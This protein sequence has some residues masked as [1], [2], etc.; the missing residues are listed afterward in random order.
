MKPHTNIARLSLWALAA[1][2]AAAYLLI[3]ARFGVNIPMDDDYHALQNFLLNFLKADGAE[4]LRLM[5]EA[6]NMHRLV[7]MR[8]VVLGVY[9]VSGQLNYSAYIWLTSL[10]LLAIALLLYREGAGR[11]ESKSL[12]AAI[13]FLLLFNGQNLG[14][15]LWAMSGVANIGSVMLTL[16]SIT[17]ILSERRAAFVAG[18]AVSLLTIYSNGNGMLMIPPLLVCL[19]MMKRRR[20]LIAFGLISVTAAA[21]YFI[22]LES[23]RVGGSLTDHPGVKL[24]NTFA[25]AGCNLWIPSAGYIA[26]A[27][28]AACAAIYLWG[29][30][31]GVYKTNL[32][33]Y[34]CLTTLFLTAAATA[35]GNAPVFGGESAAPWRYRIYGSMFLALTAIL[36]TNNPKAFGTTKL[37]RIFPAL[38][39]AF[40]ILS[41]L[42]CYRKAERRYEQKVVSSYRWRTAGQGLGLRYPHLEAH[43]AAGLSEAERRGLYRMPHYPLSFLHTPLRDYAGR[44]F[45]PFNHGI[46]A[47]LETRREDRYLVVEGW[48]YLNEPAALMEQE[49][50]YIYIIGVG[51]DEPRLVCRPWFERRFDVID[52][53]AK[54]D[55]GFLAVID[56]AELPS[57]GYRIE[58]G[59]RSRLKPGKPVKIFRPGDNASK[60]DCGEN[61]GANVV[62]I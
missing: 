40:C 54:A 51:G 52:D 31:R 8:L 16:L 6:G 22:K 47:R 24:L 61:S 33:V 59:L 13:I 21:L 7:L 60:R 1:L 23:S 38:A 58:I 50:I 26:V 57:E 41:T 39:L 48:A 35:A 4:K 12:L 49:D 37:R 11:S 62:R 18:I 5:L 32:C 42:Y 2:A 30:Y 17:L 36:V 19:W 43:L 27:A 14:N 28:G 10:F 56:S 9:A 15:N 3:I 29:I 55:C 20:E 53:T 25:F 44:N 34:A 46:T 45:I